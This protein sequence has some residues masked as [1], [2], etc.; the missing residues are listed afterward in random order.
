MD[1]AWQW[2]ETKT[3]VDI[4]LEST[5]SKAEW[6]VASLDV[7]QV[8]WEHWHYAGGGVGFG[9]DWHLSWQHWHVLDWGAVHGD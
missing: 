3:D 7:K 2:A 8:Q 4:V 1:V 6:A 9:L 5:D